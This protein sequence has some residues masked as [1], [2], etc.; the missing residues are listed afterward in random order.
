VP[1]DTFDV[2]ICTEVLEHLLHPEIAITEFARILKPQGKLLLSAPL[3]SGIHQEPHHY[4]GGFTPF[5]Y[6]KVL[7]EAGFGE[8]LIEANGGTLKAFGQ[9]SL[10]FILMTRPWKLDIP[11]SANVAWTPIWCVLSPLLGVAVPLACHYLDRFELEQRFT[12]GY[13]VVSVRN[14]ETPS[15]G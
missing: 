5:W 4:Y 12:I 15:P 10:R 2:I 9:E 11:L 8:T 7:H 3:G 6:K 1:D 14:D 13:H